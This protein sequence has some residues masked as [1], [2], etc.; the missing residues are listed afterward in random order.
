[1]IRLRRHLSGA[2]AAQK[3]SSIGP[4]HAVHQIG[5]NANAKAIRIPE[6][7]ARA[8]MKGIAFKGERIESTE[9]LIHL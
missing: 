3:I 5:F 9:Q 4:N 1:M 8:T 7:I 2:I 6:I